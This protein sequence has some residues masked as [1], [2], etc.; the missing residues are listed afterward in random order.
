MWRDLITW[1]IRS[2]Y[3]CLV[4]LSDTMESDSALFLFTDQGI[5]DPPASHR[6]SYCHYCLRY[7]AGNQTPSSSS[8][9][10]SQ[11]AI[12]ALLHHSWCTV[13]L[14]LIRSGVAADVYAEYSKFR[15]ASKYWRWFSPGQ[16]VNLFC[17]T[18]SLFT[19]LIIRLFQL[20]FSAETIFFSHNKLANSVF[21]PAY[22]PSRTGPNN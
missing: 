2:W 16:E 8:V 15:S 4:R 14:C 1:G 17:A 9:S 22:Q 19:R 5:R 11:K 3:R 12:L 7:L 13:W 18:K 20:I 10:L 21:Q 6:S